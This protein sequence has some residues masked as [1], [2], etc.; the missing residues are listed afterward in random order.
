M[1]PLVC[2]RCCPLCPFKAGPPTEIPPILR[3]GPE[4]GR[5]AKKKAKTITSSSPPIRVGSGAAGGL[6][7]RGPTSPS[8]YAPV[9]VKKFNQNTLLY[10]LTF[11]ATLLC[12]TL[13][14][15]TLSLSETLSNFETTTP[16]LPAR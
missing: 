10:L 1:V 4:I 16:C 11:T 13:V 5:M 8:F 7:F 14:A 9:I 3:M 12:I 2:P 15:T 6:S